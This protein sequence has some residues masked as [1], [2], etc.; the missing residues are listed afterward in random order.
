MDLYTIFGIW[1]KLQRGGTPTSCLIF[2]TLV[3]AETLV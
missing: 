1:E 3:E 2:V